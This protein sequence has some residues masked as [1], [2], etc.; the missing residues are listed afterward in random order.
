V[1]TSLSGLGISDLTD[2]SLDIDSF[3]DDCRFPHVMPEPGSQ[4]SFRYP[5]NNNGRYGGHRSRQSVGHQDAPPPAHIP[6]GTKLPFS[7]GG[8][9]QG[10][11]SA[12]QQQRVPSADDFP[13]LKSGSSAERPSAPATA[14]SGLTAAQVL[15]APAPSKKGK[16]DSEVVGDLADTFSKVR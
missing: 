2:A 9:G 14:A 12:N 15:Q 5:P 13:V 1:S 16:G 8:Q 3:R 7:P 11:N 4:P 10:Q 6:P